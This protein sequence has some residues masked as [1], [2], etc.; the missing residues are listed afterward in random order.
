MATPLTLPPLSDTQVTE[1]R[2]L[3]ET[4]TKAKLRFR[5]QIILLAEQG[6][7]VAA[8]H[9]G[10]FRR[11]DTAGGGRRQAPGG[12]RTPGGGRPRPP[13]SRGPQGQLDDPLIGDVSGCQDPGG[14][15]RRDRT[16]ISAR[17]WWGLQ[18]A[19]LDPQT[20]SQKA[21]RLRG[22]RL[23]VEVSLAGAGTPTPPPVTALVEADLLEEVPPDV[24]E[25]RSLL[26]HAPLYLQDAVQ[27]AFH[28][29]LTRVWC[30]KG[31][32]GQRLG[33]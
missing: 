11:R 17:R 18:A 22:K 6:R 10:V 27:F 2:Q 1:L 21:P 26:P 28:P 3:Y 4:T 15:H 20:Q 14:G 23:R 7:S 31:R 12:G 29:T 32:R 8:I 25:L 5:A 33:R 24:E 13:Y 9:T 30:W 19:A 16:L